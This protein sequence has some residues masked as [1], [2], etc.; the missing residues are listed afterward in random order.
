L[1]KQPNKHVRNES[2]KRQKRRMEIAAG[3]LKGK[4]AKQIASELG[5]SREWIAREQN[6][7]ET[8]DLIQRLLAKHD[9]QLERIVGKHLDAIEAGLTAL[10][11]DPEDHA[12]RMRAA[13]ESARLL[14]LRAGRRDDGDSSVTERRKFSGTMEELL[15]EYRRITAGTTAGNR[16]GEPQA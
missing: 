4:S 10:R 3:T 6:A 13:A 8:Q 1:A 11:E 2:G 7:P 9:A 16:E 5:V 12:A 14:T 15:I